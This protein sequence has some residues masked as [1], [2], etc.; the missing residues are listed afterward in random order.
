MKYMEK[1]DDDVQEFQTP[2]TL[3]TVAILLHAVENKLKKL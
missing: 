1:K 2:N 3:R